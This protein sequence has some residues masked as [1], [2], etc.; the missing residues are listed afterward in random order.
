MTDWFD[1]IARLA[2]L[3]ERIAVLADG[4]KTIVAKVE[5]HEAR[6]VRLETIVEIA[7]PDGS[8][9]RIAPQTRSKKLR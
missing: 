9:L 4:V 1:R 2:A 6:L 8:V 7:R 3:G 5:D